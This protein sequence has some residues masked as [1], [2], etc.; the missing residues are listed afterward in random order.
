[1]RSITLNGARVAKR[2]AGIV[3]HGHYVLRI[4]RHGAN[5]KRIEGPPQGIFAPEYADEETNYLS[6]CVL[7]WL[8]VRTARSPYT[9]TQ[10][11]HIRAILNQM[12]L[13]SEETCERHGIVKRGI[14]ACPL[15]TR[16]IR[17]DELH[18]TVSFSGQDGLI[19]AGE[20]VEGATRSTV[21]NLF[22]LM[23]LLYHQLTHIPS[24]IGW[25]HAICNT[26]LGQRPCY[27]LSDLIE[28]DLKVG[29]LK[30][31]G[32]L[33]T[34]GWISSDKLM[35]RSPNGAVWMQLNGDVDEG[36]NANAV[37]FDAALIPQDGAGNG[38]EELDS[39]D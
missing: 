20:Q 7:A 33:E 37:E 21:V 10:A 14:T 13:D 15:C 36:E 34:F 2:S 26:R 17:Y 1:M 39:G 30:D 3:D 22:H 23:P 6:K 19:N 31:E 24:N 27:S 25:G 29:I 9:M 38:S 5:P 4:P 8:I 16:F 35:I 18:D 28:M 11:A 32:F 12:E